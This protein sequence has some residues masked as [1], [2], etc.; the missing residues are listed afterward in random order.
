MGA[1]KP[2]TDAEFQTAVLDSDKPVVVDFWAEWCGPCRQVSPVLEELAE[3]FADQIT[4]YKM[5]VDENPQTPLQYRVS[6][7]P[8][9]NVYV[10]GEVAKSIVGARPKAAIKSELASVVAA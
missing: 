7:I 5:N 10:G 4:F 6:G 3:E 8:T 1:I 2:V 9:I